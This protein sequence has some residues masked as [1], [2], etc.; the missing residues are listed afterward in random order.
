MGPIDNPRLLKYYENTL[1]EIEGIV[2]SLNQ[3]PEN[4]LER[5]VRAEKALCERN[6]FV[7]DQP[8]NSSF[9]IPAREAPGRRPT[10]VLHNSRGEIARYEWTGRRLVRVPFD[11]NSDI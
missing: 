2:E 7:F 10:A 6:N 4:F 1:N 5:A 3:A 11:H 9:V 8:N